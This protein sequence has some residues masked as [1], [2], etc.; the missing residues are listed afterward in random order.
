[1]VK[2]VRVLRVKIYILRP[3][4]GTAVCLKMFEIIPRNHFIGRLSA[5][6][7]T[8]KC[9]IACCP[10]FLPI[11]CAPPLSLTRNLSKMHPFFQFGCPF[12]LFV[13]HEHINHWMQRYPLS[14]TWIVS[15]AFILMCKHAKRQLGPSTNFIF[16][17]IM[18][19]DANSIENLE[20]H[21]CTGQNQLKTAYVVTS[22]RHHFH[23]FARR[24]SSISIYLQIL[25]RPTYSALAPFFLPRAIWNFRVSFSFFLLLSPLWAVFNA[26]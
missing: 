11:E 13:F 5:S 17:F 22:Y 4:S 19:L 8:I 3:N 26:K 10:L 15:A 18:Y 7:W 1:M 2:K 24:F 23:S 6:V 16:V 9:A 12:V 25:A 14:Y 21:H 20:K